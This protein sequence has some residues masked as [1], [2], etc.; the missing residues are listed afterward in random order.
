MPV[1]DIEAAALDWV[2]RQRD[3]A[4]D[5]WEAF[6]IWLA[7][8]AAHAEIYAAMALAD[9]DMA[10]VLA[11]APQ[12]KVVGAVEQTWVAAPQPGAIQASLP[13]RR[14]RGWLGGAVAASVIAVAGVAAWQQ[15]AETYVVETPAGVRRDMTLADGSRLQINGGTRLVLDHNHQRDIIVERGEVAFTVVHDTARPFR[16]GVGDATLLDIGTMFNVVRAAGLTRVAVAEGAIVFNPQA[17][18]VRLAAGHGLV[19]RDGSVLVELVDVSPA[20]V[21]T[22]RDGR[23]VYDG[24]RLGEVAD[25]LSRNLG[26]PIA[27]DSAV[28]DQRFHGVINLGDDVEATMAAVGLLLGIK[29]T[30]SGHGWRFAVAPA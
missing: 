20:A 2:I 13:S 30:P 16:V 5:G 28:A 9:Q 25:D 22:W 6:E 29:V 4:F 18:A 27:V 23:L 10:A 17:E 21:G 26:V 24:A 15:R 8:D 11:T 1:R 7:A 14:L 12:P 19:S 3:D